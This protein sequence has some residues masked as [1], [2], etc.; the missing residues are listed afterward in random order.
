MAQSDAGSITGT[1]VDPAGA[2]LPGVLVTALN[3]ATGVSAQAITNY[4]G[5]Y[6]FT[7]LRVGNYTL[8][9][10]LAKFKKELHSG[11]VVQIQERSR[12]DFRLQVG[13][14]TEEVMVTA[15]TPLLET[16]TSN[17]G[18]VI[19]SLTIENLPLN[20]RNFIQLALLAA[21]A[22]PSYRTAQRDNFVANGNRPIQN[23]YFLDGMDN[24]THIVGFDNSSALAHRPSVDAIQEFKVQTSTFSAEYGQGAGAVVN[25]TIKSGTNGLHGTLFEFHRNSALDGTPYFQPAGTR[26]PVFIENQ[27][28]GTVGGPIK[29]NHS[30]FF[31]S[32]EGTRI[33]S[34]APRT[35]TVPTDELHEGRFGNTRIF[36]PGTTR[37]NPGG[38]GYVRDPFADNLIPRNRWD[39]V[40]ARLLELFPRA[41]L[42]GNVNNY[43]YNP[44]QR[45]RSE[46]IDIRVD[47][48]MGQTGSLFARFSLS[49]DVNTLPPLLPPPANDLS[50]AVVHGR[51]F[52][53]GYTR[54]FGSRLVNEF[55][56]GFNRT[57]VNQDIDAPRRFEEFGIKGALDDPDIKGLPTF[58]ISGFSPLGG[59]GLSV[60]LPVSVTGSGNLPTRKAGQTE[61]VSDTL[62]LTRDSH[63]IKFGGEI[64]WNL[65]NANTTNTGR[66]SFN[67]NGG[68]TQD[69]L[70]RTGTGHPFADF[71]LG[72]ANT[73][74][75]STRSVSGLRNREYL[76]F[77]Q[78]DWK[79]TRNLT[80]NIGVRYE[81]VTPFWEVNNRQ[82]NFIIDR[83]SPDFSKLVIA[84]SR[85]NSILERSFSKLDTNNFAPRAGFAYQFAHRTILRGGF[86]IFYGR[87]EDLGVLG[88]LT[89]NPPFFVQITF[90]TD[91]INPRIVLSTGFPPGILDP[92][93]MVDPTVNT[94]PEDFPFPYVQQWSLNLEHEL[95]GSTLFQ[96][97]YVGSS[98]VKLWGR[99]NINRP[100]PGPGLIQPRRPIQ[101]VG[102]IVLYCPYIKANYHSLF[103]KLERRF[104]NG[105]SFLT[106]Y[107]LGHAIDDG[108]F[109]NES[110]AVV[111]DGRNWRAERASSNNDI[112]HRFIS[113]FIHDLPLGRGRRF[114]NREGAM[115]TI[116]GGWR[117]TG[118]VGLHSGLPFT[119][120]LNSDPS[121]SLAPA[122]PDRL[123]DGNL[124]AGE[125]T[126]QRYFDLSAFQA[127]SGFRF[128]NAGRNILRGPGL[129]NFDFGL[130]R[131]FRIREKVRVEFRVE[132][133]NAF[134]TPHFENPNAV[135]GTPQAGVIQSVRAPERQIQF[136]LK[137][138]Y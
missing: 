41:N 27:F 10:E 63:S 71:L 97:G 89:N 72:L 106:S 126:L 107:T 35:S 84:G 19:S 119:P 99:V 70:R 15:E 33:V 78:D 123:T 30:F 2:A 133:F 116:L 129:V 114:L 51:S 98:S 115:A 43:F 112:R 1:V 62:S 28:G 113:S 54:T 136:G 128:G 130:H 31:F 93:N 16:E 79:A 65:L 57:L 138:L 17:L 91:R 29:P 46:K 100:E 68:F 66:P 32:Y 38:T 73:A 14:V 132:L 111:Q 92:A 120:T 58:F 131:D 95:P 48:R 13:D 125:R 135:I 12:V 90:P 25:A 7:P 50:E 101:G 82:S 9:A 6:I 55:R 45:V 121:N 105:V 88:R 85:G 96:A 74:A 59:A 44:K 83:L 61:S 64:R 122:R 26:K 49:N 53:L 86:G 118:I 137:V 134:N 4:Q 36:D 94:F 60:D 124:P 75:V 47:H 67:F 18:Q 103:L 108:K 127:P 52:V 34:A 37:S 8:S 40:A 69:P 110:G 39:P 102:D 81:L 117:W 87:D 3:Q 23:S 104:S 24:K 11:V 77:V 21:G 20:G 76:F 22:T 80:V 42:P 109:S 56:G 5:H